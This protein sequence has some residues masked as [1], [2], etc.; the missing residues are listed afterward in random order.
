MPPVSFGKLNST[1]PLSV[2]ETSTIS[3]LHRRI[4][5]FIV[6]GKYFDY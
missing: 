2:E 6:C 3:G 4:K 1:G 5:E